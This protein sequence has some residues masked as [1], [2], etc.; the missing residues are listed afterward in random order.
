MGSLRS[1][2][3]VDA[4]GWSLLTAPLRAQLEALELTDPVGFRG[5]FDGSAAAAEEVALH[6]GGVAVDAAGLVEPW[7]WAGDQPRVWDVSAFVCLRPLRWRARNQTT[8]D[9][10]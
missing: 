10:H 4:R 2:T 8:H 6:F 5:L 9:P 1:S 3:I 7:I